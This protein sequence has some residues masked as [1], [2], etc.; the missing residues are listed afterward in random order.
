MFTEDLQVVALIRKLKP[1][2]QKGKLNGIGGKVEEGEH[3]SEAMARE[4]LEE[5][6]HSTCPTQWSHYCMMLGKNDGGDEPFQV[7]FFACRTPDIGLLKSMEEETIEV[8]TVYSLGG[9][10]AMVENLSW[11]VAL[12]VD[13]LQDGR[14]SFVQ[15]FYYPEG[16]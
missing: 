10:L 5:T 7:D 12:A 16:R 14:P 1:S 13:H 15:A 2:W 11:L 8:H 4:F 9:S 6:G 3:P